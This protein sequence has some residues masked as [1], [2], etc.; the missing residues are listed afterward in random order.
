MPK[1][2][3]SIK[4]IK[5]ITVVGVCF[6]LIFL[7]P[8]GF[9]NP[10]RLIFLEFAYPFQKTFYILGQNIEET[11]SFFSSIGSMRSENENLI[12]ENNS[13]IS[14]VTS[15]QE[16]RKENEVLREQLKLI[17]RDKF[18][19]VSSSV[20]AQNPQNTGSWI[21]IDRGSSDGISVGMPVIVSEGILI[22]T[23]GDVSLD[24]SKV[25][26]LTDPLSLV[27]ASDL[28]TSARGIVTGVYGLGI[29]MDMV[30]QIDA[31]KTGDTI[32]TS[33]LGGD[34]PKGLL[35]GKIQEINMSSDKLFQQAVVIPRIRYQKLDL[36]F[37]IKK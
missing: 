19:L 33:G 15:L 27:N 4:L 9:F 22:G 16:T 3:L 29:V 36:V 13:L 2:Y 35:I 18:D 24:S 32:I 7:N 8:K 34:I 21:V 10:V 26:L 14:E 23:I 6:L 12:R 37:V 17:P 5:F 25:T 20:I 11:F 1:K 28:E 30:A 31:L